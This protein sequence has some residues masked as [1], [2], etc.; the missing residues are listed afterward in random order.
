MTL[1]IKGVR[2]IGGNRTYHEPA[3][4][5]VSGDKIS[6]IGNFPNKKADDVIDGQGAY[7]APGFIDAQTS[8]DRYLALLTDPDQGD[9]LKQGVTTIVGGYGGVSLVPLLDGDLS[10]LVPWASTHGV[11]VDWRTVKEF[12]NHLDRRPLGVNFATFVGHLTVRQTLIG[13]APRELTLNERR[14]FQHVLDRALREGALGLSVGPAAFSRDELSAT[15]LKPLIACLKEHHGIYAPAVTGSGS[16]LK[17]SLVEISQLLKK[18]GVPALVTYALRLGEAGLPA[19]QAGD[20]T[21]FITVLESLSFDSPVS[22]DVSLTPGVVLPLFKYLPEWAQ[23]GSVADMLERL[24]VSLTRNRIFEELPVVDP[25]QLHIIGAAHY[26]PSGVT[27]RDVMQL[28]GI[29]KPTEALVKLME[30]TKLQ[31]VTFLSVREDE[32]DLRAALR[33][34]RAFV[35]SRGTSTGG[36]RR[37]PLSRPA[38]LDV[39]PQLLSRTEGSHFLPLKET[40]EKVTRHPARFFGF[41]RRGEVREG[42]FA[43]L[44]GFKGSDVQFVVVNGRVAVRGGELQGVRAGRAL[45]RSQSR[46]E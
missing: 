7:L 16:E 37:L 38:E 42:Y 10:S 13:D 9:F 8:S 1:L 40:I 28:Y 12:F 46:R 17:G 31:A 34:P 21:D 45:R 22:F 41:E 33:H 27:L 32:G 18:S 35:S 14:V 44:V 11:N 6:A 19:G 26:G 23:V 15:E 36:G 24:D 29:H 20:Y 3:D 30:A 43:D 2:I 39:F 4:L 25:D 5:F